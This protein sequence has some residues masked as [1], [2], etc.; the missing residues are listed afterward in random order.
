M[1]Q[2]PLTRRLE[3]EERSLKLGR[4]GVQNPGAFLF[5]RPYAKHFERSRREVKLIGHHVN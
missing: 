1:L 4:W 5:R 3:M 2:A